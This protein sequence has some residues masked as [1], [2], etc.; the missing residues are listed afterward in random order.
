MGATLDDADLI[1]AAQAMDTQAVL[2]SD[3]KD[4]D[5]IDISRENWISRSDQSV[6][7]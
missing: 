3:D 1:L 5:L 7:S 4:F 2:V 6:K